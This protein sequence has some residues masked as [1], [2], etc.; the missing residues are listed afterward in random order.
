MEK[1]VY[2]ARDIQQITGLCLPTIYEW[3]NQEG[4]LVVC[5]GRKKLVPKDAFHAWLNAQ[6]VAPDV[7]K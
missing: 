1:I 5:V 2:T 7:Q 3:F 6:A 4:F